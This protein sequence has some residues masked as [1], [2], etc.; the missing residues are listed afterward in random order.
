VLDE[1]FQS[2]LKST[3]YED[4]LT[5]KTMRKKKFDVVPGKSFTGTDFEKLEREEHGE[6]KDDNEIESA[7]DESVDAQSNVQLDDDDDVVDKSE[8]K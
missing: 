1:S 6:G 2:L 7:C 5:V 3:R 4:E 8:W